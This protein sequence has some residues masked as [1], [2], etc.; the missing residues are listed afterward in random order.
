MHPEGA[1][2]LFQLR[3]QEVPL[4]KQLEL[5]WELQ[6]ID[7]ALRDITEDRERYPKE[8]KRLDEKCRIEKERVQKEKEKIEVLE[9]ER[10][11]KELH[12]TTEQDKIKRTESRMF[13]V[14]T[15]KEYQAVLTE[16]EGIKEG[17]NREEEEILRLLDE[18][19]EGKKNLSKWEKEATATLEKIE[20]ERKVI[21]GKMTHDDAG[22]EKQM[23]R[24]EVLGKQIEARLSKLYN[25]LKERRRG[26]GV[27]NVK[28][29]TCQGCFLNIPPQMYIEVQKNNALIQ[30]PNCNRILYWNGNGK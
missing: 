20:A 22:W 17:N 2:F 1:L 24:K 6:Q 19:D 13:E 8:M 29:E 9:K 12:L 28:N 25:T 3:K 4:R 5:L 15:N 10:R 23:Q 11:Q 26:V 18:I 7:L 14:K 27:V 30:C 16:I 21:Q